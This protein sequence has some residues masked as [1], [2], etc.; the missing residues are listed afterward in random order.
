MGEVRMRSC[1]CRTT[2]RRRCP[3]CDPARVVFTACSARCL[4]RHLTT[5][6]AAE[7]DSAAR[8]RDSLQTLNRGRQGRDLYAPHR[9]RLGRLVRAVQRG[10]GLCVLGAGNCDD[11]DLPALAR[12]FGEVHLV[13]LDGAALAQALEALPAPARARIVTHP[14]LDLSGTLE[15]LDAWGEAFPSEAALASLSTDLAAAVTR[16]VGRTF[17]VVLSACLLSQLY[18]PLRQTLILGLEPWRRLFQAIDRAHLA[19]V[20]ALTRPGGSGVLALDV[21]SSHKLPALDAFASP[22]S[23]DALESTVAAALAARELTL[24]PDPHRLLRLCEQPP[25]ET[26]LERPRLTTP[27]VW[28]TGGGVLA[29]VY[30]LMFTTVGS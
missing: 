14:G 26:A 3:V 30:A 21:A 8:A 9:D 11:L 13:D 10:E 22:D 25:F 28:S 16:T 20:A 19:T 15:R 6:H 5:Q 18:Q 1:G 7:A 17:D 24:D 23:W 27:W 2:P 12:D 29:L 4:H